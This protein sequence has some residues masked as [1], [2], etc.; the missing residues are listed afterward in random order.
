[1]LFPKGDLSDPCRSQARRAAHVVAFPATWPQLYTLSLQN[2]FFLCEAKRH[3]V[4]IILFFK[5]NY[6][7]KYLTRRRD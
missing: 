4:I 3:I 7:S 5:T 2:R 1:M 6:C